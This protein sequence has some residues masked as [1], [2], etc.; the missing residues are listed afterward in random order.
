MVSSSRGTNEVERLVDLVGG[1]SFAWV[2]PVV[3]A[4]IS[5]CRGLRG[6]PTRKPVVEPG[7]SAQGSR[8]RWR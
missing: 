2:K 7:R 3:C 5:V 8:P 1:A 4:G 6:W